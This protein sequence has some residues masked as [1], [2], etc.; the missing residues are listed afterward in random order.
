MS[1]STLHLYWQPTL[2]W[3]E[4][5]AGQNSSNSCISVLGE[6]TSVPWSHIWN[7]WNAPI[8]LSTISHQNSSGLKKV[9]IEKKQQHWD[10]FFFPPSSLFAF[11][12]SSTGLRLWITKRR[13]I[14][15]DTDLSHP[16][17]IFLSLLN[18]NTV[19][20]PRRMP[21]KRDRQKPL[22]R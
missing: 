5:S 12:P 20:I 16:L 4:A 8:W 13:K 9:W 1:N 18:I 11:I 7:Q 10:V 14:K 3:V 2:C 6:E 17:A 21:A 22:R 15:I 19:Q